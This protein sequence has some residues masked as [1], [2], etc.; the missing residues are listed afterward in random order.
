MIRRRVIRID[1]YDRIFWCGDWN[2]HSLWCKLFYWYAQHLFSLLSR[3][4][5]IC[6][7]FCFKRVVLPLFMS[8]WS[9]WRV[10]LV[11]TSFCYLSCG[12][13]LT[14]ILSD[15][16]KDSLILACKH[17]NWCLTFVM[18]EWQQRLQTDSF[19]WDR[20]HIS[21]L[22]FDWAGRFDRNFFF[23]FAKAAMKLLS[24]EKANCNDS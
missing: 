16:I 20:L 1:L 21:R 4:S 14:I 6:W 13:T 17:L 10:N 3:R 9:S 19:E 11:Q 22:L 18:F 8:T 15:T 24:I 12:L 5:L 23:A 2:L 7:L